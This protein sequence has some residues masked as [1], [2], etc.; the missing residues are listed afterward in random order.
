MKLVVGLGNPGKEYD[1]TRHN[2]GFMVLD[3]LKLDWQEQKKFKGL[4]AKQGDLLYLKP[5]TFMNH[6][7]EAVRA[8]MDYYHVTVPELLVVFDDKDLPLGTIRFRTKGS[9]GG[10]NGL[11]SIIAHIGSEEFARY[12]IGIAPTDPERVMGDTA[13]YVLAKFS[14][15]EK[16]ALPEIMKTVTEK[17]AGWL[18][19]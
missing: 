14:P 12:K 10:H 1:H 6:S 2:V 4:L 13:D 19:E 18:I 11:K 7:G 9:S 5:T 3:Q 15:T 17:I 16:K 8:V